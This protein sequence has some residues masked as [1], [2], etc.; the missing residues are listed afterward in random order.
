[1]LLR[2]KRLSEKQ[3]LADVA[4]GI[5]TAAYLC[6]IERGRVKPSR[7]LLNHLLR[8]LDLNYESDARFIQEMRA[9]IERV[10]EGIFFERDLKQEQKILAQYKTRIL[11]SPLCLSYHVTTDYLS[12]SVSDLEALVPYMDTREK[13]LYLLSSLDREQPDL[14]KAREIDALLRNSFGKLVYM[15]A[16]LHNSRFEEVKSLGEDCAA[17]ALNEG[18][19]YN[20]IQ[21]TLLLGTVYASDGHLGVATVYYERAAHLIKGSIW[22]HLESSINYNLGASLLEMGERT[23]AAERLRKVPRSYGFYLF[24]KLAYLALAL[25]DQAEARHEIAEMK[26][27]VGKDAVR[28]SLYTATAIQLKEDFESKTESLLVI[29]K[30][31]EVL[32]QSRHM[33]YL[34]FHRELI[35]KVFIAQRMYKQAYAFEKLL[36][37]SSGQTAEEKICRRQR[38]QPLQAS[39]GRLT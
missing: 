28:Q 5:C 34:R 23:K 13:A 37:D 33:G 26:R 14:D 24:H 19:L 17:A 27:C 35:E 12:N 25:G 9:V 36:C 1:M 21:V 10:F 22:P 38:C 6:K 20:L 16:C 7:E 15:S 8:K 11:R 39:L 3:E 30:L 2:N 32:K 4:K 29:E 18:N 31:I